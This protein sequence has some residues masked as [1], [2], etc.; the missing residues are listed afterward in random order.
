MLSCSKEYN[1]NNGS[2]NDDVNEEMQP[3]D[4]A[5][6]QKLRQPFNLYDPAKGR[7]LLGEFT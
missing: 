1:E 6:E 5:L 3:C 2:T 7:R 4:D